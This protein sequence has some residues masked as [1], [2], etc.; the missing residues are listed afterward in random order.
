MATPTNTTATLAGR[1]A[2]VTGGTQGIGSGIA[3]RLLELGA[4][5]AVTA[6]REPDALPPGA[7]FVQGDVSS[8]AGVVAVA[9][10]A[11]NVLGGVDILVNNAGAA[12]AHPGGLATISDE[13]WTGSINLNLLAA[14]RLTGALTEWIAASPA[15]VIVNLSSSNAHA[16]TPSTAHYSVAKAALHA[17]T[18]AASIEL[19]PRGVRVN[20]VVP[21]S[22]DS[23]GGNGVRQTVADA[24]GVPV[25][26]LSSRI[27]LGRI[28][29]PAD[30]A[31]AVAFLVSDDASW[32]TGAEFVVDGGADPHA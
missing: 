22:V 8:S 31:G 12:S 7:V 18:K 24:M 25:A 32:I 19:A 28:G 29:Q 14:V 13:E 3:A 11:T 9:R 10:A 16:P 1:R 17:F 30:I 20:T 4:S 15:G 6:R 5:V 27:P 23:A 26:A 21:G 2:L